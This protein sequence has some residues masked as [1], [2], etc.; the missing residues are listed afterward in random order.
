MPFAGC[1]AKNYCGLPRVVRTKLGYAEVKGPFVNAILEALGIND[2]PLGFVLG[3]VT[4]AVGGAFAQW[5]G[6][7]ARGGLFLFRI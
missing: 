6:Y 4:L 5:Q 2:D 1:V 7:Q 3:G